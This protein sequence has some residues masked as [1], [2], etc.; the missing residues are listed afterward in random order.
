[1]YLFQGTRPDISFS[2]GYCSR[3]MINPTKGDWNNVQRIFRYLCGTTNLKL[4]Y[5]KSAKHYPT[6]FTDAS[7][8]S[9]VA[10]R[11]STSGYVFTMAGA[12]I[13][14]RSKKQEI[15]AGSTTEAEYIA[16]YSAVT[17]CMWLNKLISNVGIKPKVMKIFADNKSSIIL[18]ENQ[19]HSDRSK[20]I[21]IKYHFIREKVLKKV[22]VFCHI[23]TTDLPAD[24]LT[25]GLSKVLVVRHRET[26]GLS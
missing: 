19:I 11:K 18:S 17:H 14:W 8:A 22:F 15:V 24:L 10:D 25:K 21:D 13:S 3:F 16:M 20:H 26:M 4:T 1:M 2:V 9:D 23:P 6:G 12:A 5:S 7:F